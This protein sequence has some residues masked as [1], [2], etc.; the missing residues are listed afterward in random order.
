MNRAAASAKRAGLSFGY[1]NHA[2]EFGKLDDGTRPIDTIL[3]S[4]DPALVRFEVDVFWVSVT[5]NDPVDF[6]KKLGK[7]VMLVH[8]KDKAKDTPVKF[9]EDVEKAAFAEVGSGTVDIPGVLKAAEAL[10]IEHYFVEQD[11]SP[12]PLASLKKSY[13]YLAKQS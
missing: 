2:F 6:I 3:T 12:D 8:L 9:A 11:Q 4:F 1:H 5:G 13:E 7:R 10:G